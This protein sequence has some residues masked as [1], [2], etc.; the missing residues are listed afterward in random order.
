MADNAM[1]LP[2]KPK[3]IPTGKSLI[4]LSVWDSALF[5]FSV[6]LSKSPRTVKRAMR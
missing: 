4:K 1:T 3:T 5:F 2:R 6:V